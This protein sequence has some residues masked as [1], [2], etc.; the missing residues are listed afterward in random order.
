MGGCSSSGDAEIPKIYPSSILENKFKTIDK[1]AFLVPPELNAKVEPI[2]SNGT[3]K[4]IKEKS[5][6]I[7][8][9]IPRLFYCHMSKLT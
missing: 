2:S 4:S 9:R 1:R 7:S 3:S 6:I 8:P 5:Q